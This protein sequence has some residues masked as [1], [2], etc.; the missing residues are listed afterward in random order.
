MLIA[1]I[2]KTK[3]YEITQKQCK[4][5]NADLTKKFLIKLLFLLLKPR[6]PEHKK[7]HHS[8]YKN[9]SHKLYREKFITVILEPLDGW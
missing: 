7:S 5:I 9:S 3:K 8:I 2:N 1:Y 4:Q 6:K